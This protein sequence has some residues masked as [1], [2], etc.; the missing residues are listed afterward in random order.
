MGL[1]S[2]SI[3]CVAKRNAIAF[4]IYG[5]VLKRFFLVSLS[6]F[7]VGVD[8]LY[9]DKA[10]KHHHLYVYKDVSQ[11]DHSIYQLVLRQILH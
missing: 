2:F 3:M 8:E 7:L 10:I 5:F 4:H 11:H 6:S 9:N 1:L